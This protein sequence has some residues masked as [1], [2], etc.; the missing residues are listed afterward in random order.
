MTNESHEN[1]DPVLLAVISNRL[2]SIVREMTNTLLRSARSAVIAM[3][4]DFS[5]CIATGQHE[6]LAMAEAAPVH[7]FGTHLQA[8]A[9]AESKRIEEQALDAFRRKD[10]TYER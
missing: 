4:R 1:L 5:C 9:M 6:L 8:E 3:S 2:D 7:V 10:R